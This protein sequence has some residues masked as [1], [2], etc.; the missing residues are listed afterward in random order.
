MK[1]ELTSFRIHKRPH[2]DLLTA[3]EQQILN[4]FHRL[5][6]GPAWPLVGETWHNTF[7]MGVNT[8]KCPLDLWIYQEIVWEVRPDVIVETGTAYGGTSLF[9]AH[10]CDL[11]G[12]GKIITIDIETKGNRPHH[13]RI[14][15]LHGSSTSEEIRN[16]IKR[17]LPSNA[18][19]IVILDSDHSKEHVLRE[20]MIYSEF[21]STG[22]YIIVEDT[23]LN[24]HPV[25]GHH[26][27]GPM[28][29]VSEFLKQNRT[30]RI[31][32]SREKFLMTFNPMGYLRRVGEEEFEN[33]S[34]VSRDETLG[35][36]ASKSD[37]L[38]A[39]LEVYWTRSD[40]ISAFPEVKDGDY[41]RVI[42]WASDVIMN[43]IDAHARLKPYADWYRTRTI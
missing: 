4:D 10:L 30:F 24:G 42:Q 23:N 26:G 20:L 33:T 38:S 29:A 32:R 8:W 13:G 5:Y 22:S 9:L 36:D 27:P 21:V 40:L 12:H 7:W 39:L 25:A 3:S 28:E 2:V 43:R 14:E 11:I 18:K 37:P 34:Y 16:Q 17:R 41:K 15:Y 31:D 35:R 6:Y 1:T 19:V